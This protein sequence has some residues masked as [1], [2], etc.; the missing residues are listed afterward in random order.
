MKKILFVI[1]SLE[2]G[3]AEKA[4]VNLVNNMDPQKF[5]IS[6]LT[7]FDGGPNKKFLNRN[8]KYR[9]I[10]KR[11]F[12]GLNILLKMFTP[13]FLAKKFL[14]EKYDIVVS[15]L[16]G[17]TA[18]IVSGLENNSTVKISWVHANLQKDDIVK[19]YR[20]YKEFKEAY[21]KFNSVVFVSE[22]AK[23]EFEKHTGLVGN[24]IVLY[25]IIETEKIIAKSLE[26]IYN[27]SFDTKKVNLITVGRL[28][29]IKGYDR[30]LAVARD[31]M[32][33]E[34]DFHLYILGVGPLEQKMTNFIEV[35]KLHDHVTILG[36]KQN[37]YKY[38]K[39]ADLFICSSYS[40]GFSIA[41]AESL[42]VGTPVLTTLESMKELLGE[43]EFGIIVDNQTEA[44][45]EGV[46]S[47]LKNPE[48]LNYYRKQSKKGGQNFNT[49][50]S[51]EKTEVF[52]LNS[53]K[54]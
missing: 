7:I 21:D 11:S 3:G 36:Y 51:V 40:E 45:L 1:P 53:T 48:K 9:Y 26:P 2:G 42:I 29:D 47:L 37:P 54:K 10:F 30:L 44:L 32:L 5:D 33:Q 31:L 50:E 16:Q 14:K 6:L 24:H 25:N 15:Y 43:N 39:K 17:P 27:I 22:A 38:V 12:K 23:M 20:N 4:L 34:W 18:R 35:N 52:L 46:V 49:N 28:T 41:V 19:F 8:I 13:K